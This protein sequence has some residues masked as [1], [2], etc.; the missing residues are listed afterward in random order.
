MVASMASFIANDTL[1]KLAA[2]NLPTGEIVFIRNGIASA[3]MLLALAVLV[4]PVQWSLIPV[5]LVGWR[6]LGEI[7]GTLLYLSALLRLPIA[8]ITAIGQFMPLAV[9]AA[10]AIFLHEPVG[11]RRW[12]AAIAGLVGVLI[13]VRPGTSAFTPAA[14]L[15]IVSIAFFTL[16]DLVTRAISA[17]VPTLHLT[18]I[19][20]VSVWAT[21]FALAPF[22]TWA[23]PAPGQMLLL[24]CAAV[25]LLGGYSGIIVAMRSGEIGVVAPFR[26]AVILWAILSGYFVWGEVPDR[27]TALG[28]AIVVGAGLYT[29][30]REQV[31]RREIA[32][33]EPA[34]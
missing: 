5:R 29:V 9:T 28:I 15:A 13:I 31:R 12:L 4:Q 25:F 11:W 20:A 3:I 2:Q 6:T 8:D 7:G 34:D 10:A 1:M 16:R 27:E 23:Q 24:A 19:S 22:E 30:H 26:Y 32:R 33:G 21:S 17:S 14:L 18:L